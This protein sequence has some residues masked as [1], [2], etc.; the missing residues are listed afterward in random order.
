MVGSVA[1]GESAG[2]Q[3]EW[4]GT[5][6]VDEHGWRGCAGRHRVFQT[7]HYSAA[8]FAAVWRDDYVS[9]GLDREGSSSE[10]DG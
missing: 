10:C 8:G 9:G 6:M 4:K 5:R 2:V 3:G 7:R 1:R